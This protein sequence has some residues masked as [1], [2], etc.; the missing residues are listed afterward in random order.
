[1]SEEAEQ[2]EEGQGLE[3]GA[4]REEGPRRAHPQ[5]LVGHDPG[6]VVGGGPPDGPAGR[7]DEGQRCGGEGGE[8]ERRRGVE[9]EEERR[10]REG[11][12]GPRGHWGEPQP[13]EG[14]RE[15]LWTPDAGCAFLAHKTP[16]GQYMERPHYLSKHLF[17]WEMM[18]LILGGDSSLDSRSFLGPVADGDQVKRFLEGYGLGHDDPVTRAE[19]FGNFQE[20]LQFVRRYFLRE[21]SEDGLEL[22]VPHSLQRISDV[23]E[24]FMI[25]V[26]RGRDREEVCWAEALLKVMHTILHVDKDLR[27]HY[28]QAIQ[29][30]IFDRFYKYLV[31]SGPEERLFL[32]AKGES[33]GIPLV[34]FET[35]SMKSRE[36][37]II[38]LLHKAENVAE[39]VFDR[40]GVRMVTGSRLDALRA[41]KFL[42]ERFI[43]IPHN[44]KPSRSVNGLV[45]LARFQRGHGRAVKAALRGNLPEGEFL[46][47]LADLAERC[48]PKGP[49]GGGNNLHSLR[50][51]RSIQFTCPPAHQVPGP[52]LP[53]VRRASPA[54][55]GGG[56]GPIPWRRGSSRWRWGTSPG[57]CA[58]STPTRSRSWTRRP[59]GPTPRARRRTRSTRGRRVRT[60]MRRV[61]K[62]LI[63]HRGLSV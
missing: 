48:A 38:K 2:D 17:D 30:Q 53:G 24:L 35:K 54:G 50:D 4:P 43:V 36:S 6:G 40:V 19:L 41:V 5:E 9:G 14:E 31:R 18:G 62:S 39:E 23:G 29:T 34:E 59:T 20:A 37:V 22:E 33:G 60:A 7:P 52:L 49:S 42:L 25:T 28:F 16:A 21:G 10:R 1:M 46:A 44:I 45:D 15:N 13:A 51:Y 47:A 27:F 12:G 26:D 3:G 63:E 55:P 8:E 56:Q 32:G 61:F 57:R 58:S 11:A